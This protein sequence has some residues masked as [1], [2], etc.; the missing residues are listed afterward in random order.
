MLKKIGILYIILLLFIPTLSIATSDNINLIANPSFE[1]VDTNGQAN[2]WQSKMYRSQKGY[3]RLSI[4]DERARTGQYSARI[5]NASMNDSRFV[6]SAT[7]TPSTLYCLSAY[8]WVDAMQDVGAGATL[9]LENI[10]TCAEGLFENTGNWTHLTW[11]GVTG[12]KQ[13]ELDLGVR[14]GGYSAESIGVAFF[15]DISL[16]PIERL[17]M[18]VTASLWYNEAPL[19]VA[20]KNEP[21]KNTLLFLGIGCAFVLFM[22]AL[23][24]FS[25]PTPIRHVAIWF[26]FLLIVGLSV[27][28][29][30][31]MQVPG[32]EVDMNCFSAWSARMVDVG[33]A[34]FYAED[35]FC[36]YP[37]GYLL[38]LW[39]VGLLQTIIQPLSPEVSRLVT[40]SLPIIFDILISCILFIVAKKRKVNPLMLVVCYLFNP[41]VLVNGAGWGQA[42]AILAF[43]MLLAALFAM[44]KRWDIALPTYFAG[45]LL[46]PQALLF[47]PLALAWLLFVL[48]DEK[49]DWKKHRKSLCLGLSYSVIV[50]LLVVLPFSIK[51]KQAFSW[52]VSLYANTLASY[53]YATLNTANLYY[54]VGANWVSLTESVPLW[55]SLSTVLATGGI[56]TILYTN[57]LKQKKEL[58]FQ[59]VWLFIGFSILNLFYLI[60]KTTYNTYGFSMLAFVVVLVILC[61]YHHRNVKSLPYYMAL[62]LLGIYVFG[63]KVHERYLFV[64]LPLFLLSYCYQKDRRLLYLFIGLSVTTFLNTAIVL[65]NSILFGAAQ[66]HLNDDTLLLNMI[67]SVGNLLL[68]IAG[69]YMG[70]TGLRESPKHK[71]EKVT[72]LPSYYVCALETPTDTRLPMKQVDIF[73][74]IVV[75]T[76]YACLA[77][78]NLGSLVAPQKGWVSTSPNET[79]VFELPESQTFSV[80]YYAGVS[81]HDF[82]IAVS[83]DGIT[84]SDSYPCQ[85]NEGM[86]YRW[87]YALTSD[88]SAQYGNNDPSGILWKNGKYIRLQ[89]ESAGLN[90]FEIMAKDTEGNVIPLSIVSHEGANRHMI[91][92]EN[93]PHSLI[94]EPNTFEG[95]PGWFTGTYFDEIYHARTAYEH[96]HGQVP[97]ETT[98]PPLG[99]L[100]MAGGISLFGMT[101]FGWRFAGTLI[102]VLMLPALYLLALELTK[103]RKVAMLS[104]LAFSLDL[105]HFTQ[106]R[107]ATID[108]FPVFFILLSY[109]F[110]VRYLHHD[111]LALAPNEH[112][113]LYTKA[114]WKAQVM[115]LLSGIAMGLSIASKWIGLYSAVGL[116][117]LFFISI[118]RQYKMSKVAFSL[119]NQQRVQDAKQFTLKR[120]ID[121][122]LLCLIYFIVIPAIIYYVSYIPYLSPSG[123]CSITRL[124]DA[125]K[126]MFAYH[127]TPG[128]GMDHPFQSPWWQWPFI[129]KPMWYAQDTFE[130]QGY[131]STIMCLGNP[132]IFYVGAF[133]ML[134]VLVTFVASFIPSVRRTQKHNNAMVVLVLTV[135]FLAQ[136]L[137]WVLVP[138]SMYIYH[139]FASVPFIIMATAW[140]ISLLPQKI[141][142]WVAILYIFASL[143]F[144]ILFFPYSS[145]MM[146]STQWLDAV[147]WFP[148]LYY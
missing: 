70:Y 105:M 57:K 19:Q 129:H 125:Q 109:L 59:L 99:K 91:E 121:T 62:L 114:F 107:I 100:M 120:I 28:I 39:P 113:R 138:R 104:M 119:E 148:N 29:I 79:I 134:A 11:Y 47:A 5:E 101:P 45:V 95:E 127:A 71:K 23:L 137:P 63:V 7:V 144:F 13:T 116:A 40:K 115:L 74:V 73:F 64:A 33:P 12:E 110:M 52:I 51:Q 118:Y 126:G 54:L 86:C 146:V 84:W 97:Y 6:Y 36:D 53:S 123:N 65:E 117:I 142:V 55:L 14:V 58:S 21:S 25:S 34:N 8:V 35:Y 67:I 4:T 76:L 87:N 44:Q 41:T 60:F 2:Q 108:S 147:S 1:D 20:T 15:D 82:S 30:I 131:A 81:Y 128:L 102:G 48:L 27:R 80:A 135:A 18:G 85:L 122:C 9:G 3:S 83:E 143:V 103:K 43:A 32:Y 37:P 31:A 88:G 78:W 26:V 22:V 92:G 140:C 94:D 16:T 139:Y 77:F 46:K 17:P 106:T 96:L 111:S 42:D 38:L 130:P 72:S 141:R 136:Y 24:R 133:A 145:G 69:L 56:A 89:V 49:A 90:L 61:F 50:V 124:I 112:S 132:V 66:G 10:Y 93:S 75:T 68:C 98:H